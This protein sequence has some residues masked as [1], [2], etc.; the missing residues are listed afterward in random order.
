MSVT[1][2]ILHAYY[3]VVCGLRDYLRGVLEPKPA[4]QGPDFEPHDGDTPAYRALLEGAYVALPAERTDAR[5]FSPI[6]PMV[7]V[8]EIIDRAQEKLFL[9]AR[10]Q[11]VIT[12]GYRRVKDGGDWGKPGFG[13]VL[14]TNYFVNTVV[15]ALQAPEWE[16]LFQRIGDDA[17]FHLLTE[18]SV[19][20][21]LPNECLC[22]V[23][24]EP[25]VFLKPPPLVAGVS[26]NVVLP[27]HAPPLD[28][29]SPCRGVKRQAKSASD[30]ESDATYGPWPCNAKVNVPRRISHFPDHVCSTHGPASSLAQIELRSAFLPHVSFSV[31]WSKRQPTMTPT[32][33]L[34][35]L[36]SAYKR[37]SKAKACSEPWVD[38]DPREQ[39][40]N[41]RHLSKFVFP[42]Q[43]GLAN[44]FFVAEHAA[45]QALKQLD[46]SNQEDEIEK[47]GP[48][49]TPKRLKPVLAMLDQ[50]IWRHGKCGYK[51]LLNI[52]CPSKIRTENERPLDSSII[53]E[54]M[55]E[56]SSQLRSQPTMALYNDSVDSAGNTIIA[57]GLSQARKHVSS[58]PRFAEFACSYVEVYRYAVL[59]TNAVIPKA[60]WGCKRNKKV[61]LRQIKA[62]IS[63][64]RYETTTL[65][66]VL[67]KFSITECEWLAPEGGAA[68]A[69]RRVSV[70]DALK[71]RELLEEFLFWYFDSFLLPLLKTTFY[72]TES[73]ALRRR[74]LYFRQDDWSTLCAPL[75]DKLSSDTFQKMDKAEAEE[76]LRQRKLGFSFVRLLP[77]ETG[78]RPIVNL[79]RRK[80]TVPFDRGAQSINQVLQAAFQILTYEKDNQPGLLGAS[81]FGSNEIYSRLKTFKTRLLNASVDKTLPK[82]YFVKVDVQACF[83]TI[84]QTKL[85]GIIREIISELNLGNEDDHPHFLDTAAKLA[86]CLRHTVFV[87]QVV[88]HFSTKEEIIELLE[89]HIT[90][91]IVKIGHNYYRQTV[92]IPQGSVL[93]AI[94]CSFF[95][96]DLERKVFKFTDD[97]QCLLL[98]MIDD[99]LFVTTDISKARKFLAMMAK[100]HPDYGCFISRDKTLTNFVDDPS[101]SITEP[102]QQSNNILH[103]VPSDTHERILYYSDYGRYNETYLVDSLTVE[104]GRRSGVTLT[105]AKSHILFCDADLNSPRTVYLNIYQNFLLTAMKMHHYLHQ[106]GL[107]TKKS[108]PF[109]RNTIHQVIRYTYAAMRNKATNRVAKASEGR[110]VVQQAQT[111]WMGTHAFHTVLSRKPHTY[112]NLIKWLKLELMRPRSRRLKK[113]FRGIVKEG[114]TMLTLLA[115]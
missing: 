53:L 88:Y 13:R 7:H 27:D 11:N 10:P 20:I 25:I 35:R 77:K 49:K 22:Q 14:L 91:N 31:L 40:K 75:V 97:L 50:M 6:A 111:I 82:L 46:Y 66:N 48:C 94:L 19:F 67:H 114:L 104:R 43:Y 83:D 21:P 58:K 102:H 34:N 69:Q 113:E 80:A 98:R 55:S 29:A 23:M 74:I 100:G 62:F 89:E 5:R 107:N 17:M 85:L 33:I 16:T 105:K 32:D 96:G 38:P 87:D 30:C 8:R 86:G 103:M 65:H 99:Y 2:A 51:A 52:A 112:A 95:Y 64:R 37:K 54:M 9:K 12:L 45:L 59:V 101:T 108:S 78:V 79:K 68:R 84:E 71:R 106:W 109:L 63:A 115:F 1:L 61:V 70:T 81:V 92:G 15:T 44:P 93:S 76:I 36:N 4:Y 28:S 39:A 57:R 3:P 26:G 42:R 90:E 73:S 60:F 56:Y 110:F 47:K 41:A 18:A 72:V 24:G